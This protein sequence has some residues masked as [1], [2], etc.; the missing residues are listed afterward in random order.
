MNST[1]AVEDLRSTE[2]PGGHDVVAVWDE[3]PD[4]DYRRDMS[5]WRSHGRWAEETWA[6]IGAGTME[7]IERAV[8]LT[9]RDLPTGALLEWG[10]GGGANL[11]AGAGHFRRL[12]GVDIS[13]KNLDE[14]A[15]VLAEH[16]PAPDFRAVLIG[17]DPTAATTAINEPIEVFVSTAVFQHFPSREYGFEVLRVVADLLAP[18]GLGYVQI[19]YDNGKAKYQ[20]K[21]EDYFTRHTNFTSYPLD[22]FW[23]MIERAGLRPLDISGVNSKVNYAKFSFVAP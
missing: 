12:Y 14:C 11:S 20:Q 3:H 7:F 18:G 16:D 2:S 6:A 17:D 8:T 21:H 15:R 13:S 23:D 19:R 22:M 9:G 4:E 10:P 5:H 1:P